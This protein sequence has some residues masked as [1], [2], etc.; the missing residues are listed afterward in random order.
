[1]LRGITNQAH[2]VGLREKMRTAIKWIHPLRVAEAD[3][4]KEL[5]HSLSLGT[6]FADHAL[7]FGREQ[8]RVNLVG[9]QALD[10]LLVALR[11][12][13]RSPIGKPGE[14]TSDR[15]P[16]VAGAIGFERW[17]QFGQHFV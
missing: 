4:A 14:A 12:P 1:D 10:E 13:V 5:L 7:R 15:L 16:Q 2:V 17:Q 8:G 6:D 11:E 3:P 9:E